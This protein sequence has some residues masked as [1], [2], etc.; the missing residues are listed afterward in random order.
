MKVVVSTRPE[1]SNAVGLRG[2]TLWNFSGVTPRLEERARVL[3]ITE[4]PGSLFVMFA[5]LYMS[6]YPNSLGG[7][8]DPGPGVSGFG[9]FLVV[10]FD[11]LIYFAVP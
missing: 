7:I 11:S 9:I 3:L 4:V 2:V 6:K 10:L 8:Y 1:F 5:N